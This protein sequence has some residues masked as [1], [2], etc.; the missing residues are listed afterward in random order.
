MRTKLMITKEYYDKKN[1]TYNV[2]G[3]IFWK[4]K[5]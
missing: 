5:C 2:F 1:D 4:L 3:F